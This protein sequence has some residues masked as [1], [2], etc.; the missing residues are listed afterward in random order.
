MMATGSAWTCPPVPLQRLDCVISSSCSSSVHVCDQHFDAA[1]IDF[2]VL[3]WTM[4][5]PMLL[6]LHINSSRR[7]NLCLFSSPATIHLVPYSS[8]LSSTS[9]LY[10]IL[11]V[12]RL[13]I[14][15]STTTTT[16]GGSRFGTGARVYLC[17]NAVRSELM[18]QLSHRL[19]A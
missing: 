15:T 7:R 11:F 10:A 8:A 13:T 6:S 14:T 3:G 2:K 9:L 1:Y 4:L 12:P 16:L 18:L 5:G 19:R 17:Q